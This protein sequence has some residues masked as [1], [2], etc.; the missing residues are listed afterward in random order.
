MTLPARTA[1][2]CLAI[3]SDHPLLGSS[4]RAED[5]SLQR[6]LGAV[7]LMSE[8]N[9]ALA[10]GELLIHCGN[11]TDYFDGYRRAV[12][13]CFGKLKRSPVDLHVLNPA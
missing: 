4:W 11:A 2:S 7:T 9:C 3:S 13:I 5:P 8:S 10:Q 6:P 1:T 12:E